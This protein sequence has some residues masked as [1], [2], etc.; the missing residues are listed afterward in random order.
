MT[1]Y[2]GIILTFIVIGIIIIAVSFLL[3]KYEYHIS[4]KEQEMVEKK[5]DQRIDYDEVVQKIIEL[6]EYGEYLK[7]DLD[8]RQKEIVFM[9][10][11]LLDKQKEINQLVAKPS[12]TNQEVKPIAP[13]NVEIT[14]SKIINETVIETNRRSTSNL[15]KEIIELSIEGLTSTEI[16]KRLNIGKGQV[17]LVQ[18]L[19]K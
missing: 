18:N 3:G 11:L 2:D 5:I 19:Y 1:V 10:Q 9:Y 12:D 14:T 6:N 8:K 17:E 15:N 4:K 7:K 16:A 13:G